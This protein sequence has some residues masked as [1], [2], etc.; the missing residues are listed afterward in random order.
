MGGSRRSLF[1]QD[2]AILS[3]CRRPRL[4][5]HIARV[6]NVNCS[7]IRLRLD[8]LEVKGLVSV[9][10]SSHKY[11]GRSVK[12]TTFVLTDK[13]KDLVMLFSELQSKYAVSSNPHFLK[14]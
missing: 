4:I 9:V 10:D 14:A 1:E 8:L 6:A 7:S 11:R 13:G 3:A 12:K 5:T 2:M